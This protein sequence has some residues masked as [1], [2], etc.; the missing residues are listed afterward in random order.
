MPWCDF[1]RYLSRIGAGLPAHLGL[2]RN[3]VNAA[4]MLSPASPLVAAQNADEGAIPPAQ[5]GVVA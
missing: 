1:S 5:A 3:A 4:Q 2:G